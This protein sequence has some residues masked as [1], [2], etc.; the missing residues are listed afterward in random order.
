MRELGVED[1]VIFH[2]RFVEAEELVAV[3]GASDIFITPYLSE[4]QVSS[5]TLS[6]AVGAG[7]TVISTPY[8]YAQE[9]LAEDRGVLVP[10]GEH[11]PIAQAVIDVLNDDTRRHEMRKRAY[12]FGRNMTWPNVAHLYV[13]SFTRALSSTPSSRISR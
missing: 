7:K 8:W 13:E 5:G 1:N 3:I 10:F 6:W 11:A 2:N 4:E 9:L 12:M